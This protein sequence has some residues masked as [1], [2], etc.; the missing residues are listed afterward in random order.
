M[1]DG[2]GRWVFIHAD[3]GEWEWRHLSRATGGEIGRGTQTFRTLH[4]CI[5]DAHRHGYMPPAATLWR[6][7][8]ER[9]GAPL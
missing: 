9:T 6:P 1:A 7:Q 3:N 8:Q 2:L 4:V 5:A